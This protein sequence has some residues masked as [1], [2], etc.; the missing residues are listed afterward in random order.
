MRRTIYHVRKTFPKSRIVFRKLHRTDDV[1]AGTQYITNRTFQSL[2]FL[3]ARADSIYSNSV[4]L[5]RSDLLPPPSFQLI[6]TSSHQSRSPITTLARRSRTRRGSPHLWCVTPTPLFTLSL[7]LTKQ[8]LDFG[9]VFEGYQ[10]FQEKVHPLLVP[11]GVMY[12]QNLLHQLRLA[13][14]GYKL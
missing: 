8:F 4:R 9:K 6:P 5:L 11:G 7:P 2:A 3:F 13:M 1:V 10:L 14:A 12:S